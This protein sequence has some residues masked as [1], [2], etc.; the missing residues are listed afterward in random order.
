MKDIKKA[1]SY[2]KPWKIFAEKYINAIKPSTPSHDDMKIVESEVKKVVDR[3]KDTTKTNGKIKA[4]VLGCTFRYR[5]VLT[6]FGI[7]TTLTDL[8]EDMYK[9]NT[10]AIEK[11]KKVN[12]KESKEKLIITDWVTMQLNNKFE[13]ILGDFV[14]SNIMIDQRYLFLEN[15][16]RHLADKGVFITRCCNHPKKRFDSRQIAKYYKNRP[17]NL[18]YVNEL[19]PDIFYNYGYNPKTHLIHNRKSYLKF[20]KAMKAYKYMDKWV[21][22]FE[23]KIPTTKKT[24]AILKE[25]EQEKEFS[26]HFKIIKK[27]F[28]KDYKY[29]WDC[30]TYVMMRRDDDQ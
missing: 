9:T 10:Y 7:E 15:V 11:R 23:E 21:K 26:N 3:L 4:L 5:E 18:K 19:W 22:L 13:I 8:S 6:K 14:L 30:P 1:S 17:L 29:C 12:I 24:W 27:H 28:S 20:K 16:K 2:Y 25:E